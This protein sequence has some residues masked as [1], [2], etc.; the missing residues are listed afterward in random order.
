M[1][2]QEIAGR[3]LH[4]LKSSKE[5]SLLD[6]TL[7]HIFIRG[8]PF[9]FDGHEYLRELYADTHHHEVFRK[10][11]QVGIST[12]VLLKS[13]WIGD[14]RPTKVIYYFPT[15]KDVEDFSNDRA[16]PM[17]KS[18]PHLSQTIM[19]VD[20]VGLKQIGKSTLY[21]RGMFSKRAVTSV[22]ADY[23]VMDELDKADQMN[24]EF[25]KDRVL[26]SDLQWVTEL[27]QP[28]VPG[29]GIDEAFENSDQRF[30]LLKCPA[31]G[32]WNNVVD[33]FPHCMMKDK[34]GWYLGCE[35]C[36]GHLDTQAGQWVARRP[37]YKE[38]RGWHL[39]QLYSSI[40]PAG[41]PSFIAK[42]AAE[43]RNARRNHQKARIHNSIVGLPYA[44]DNQPL[45]DQT[46]RAAL[47]D[48]PMARSCSLSYMGVDVGDTLH[49]V[50]GHVAGNGLLVIHWAEETTDWDRLDS[51]ME[52]HQVD[53]CVIDA[54]PYKASA[55]A[56]ARRW[57]KQVYIQYFKGDALKKGEEGEGDDAVPKV[58]VDRTESLDR[59]VEDIKAGEILLPSLSEHSVV[60]VI[61]QHLKMLIKDLV[62]DSAGNK[63]YVY[64]KQVANHFGMAINSMRI[65]RHLSAYEVHGS[66][67]IPRGGGNLL[68]RRSHPRPFHGVRGLR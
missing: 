45:N 60:G 62:E 55:K 44:G 23:V 3:I 42:V 49:V 1:E 51:L 38:T 25:A 52:S 64:K 56:F 27:S 39:S 6:W 63:K 19:G 58:T 30:F 54:M 35:K 48:H 47:G 32:H 20:N 18:S 5:L 13:F 26:H 50:V 40:V 15:D 33:A 61:V 24:R 59:T 7:K 9:S 31:C 65:A 67:V 21:F 22:D 29:F 46:I 2:K 34:D 28:S 37:D 57:P 10:A 12:R 68:S 41:Y 53:L 43:W 17:I 14:C 11:V 16:A 36:R 66:G 8:V 4:N